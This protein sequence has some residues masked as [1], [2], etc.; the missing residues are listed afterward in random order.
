[1]INDGT[2]VYSFQGNKK[3][4]KISTNEQQS[5]YQLICYHQVINPKKKNQIKTVL[6]TVF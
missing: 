6:L 5:P 4:E 1:M 2:T 3:L